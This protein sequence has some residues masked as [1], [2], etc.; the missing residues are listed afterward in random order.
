M[1]VIQ[2]LQFVSPTP[3]VVALG[4]FDGVHRGHAEIIR[5]AV[6]QARQM[7]LPCL[8]WSFSEPPRNFFEAQSVSLLTLSEQKVRLMASFGVDCFVSVPFDQTVASLSAEDFLSQILCRNL[9]ARHIVCGFNYTFGA[10]KSGNPEFLRQFCDR[11]R[12]GLTVTEP[13]CENGQI[14]SSSLIRQAI[15]D[16]DMETAMRCLGRPYSI[17]A[18]V[19]QGQHLARTLG[20]PTVNQLLPER[21]T[22]PRYGVYVSHVRAEDGT[23]YDGITN[24]G[25]RPTVKGTLLCAETHLFDVQKDFYGQNLCIEFLAF[26]RPEKAFPSLEALSA[27]VRSDIE[28]AK[29]YVT[30]VTN[31]RL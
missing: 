3:T 28:R 22:V 2:S 30:E 25:M 13:V 15:A 26:L 16:G 24:V 27:Q 23:E 9:S 6:C 12:I 1:R 31:S 8:V 14:I 21:L 17:A 19:T 4:C 10:E 20:F 11:R 18:P 7:G 5:T 29:Q